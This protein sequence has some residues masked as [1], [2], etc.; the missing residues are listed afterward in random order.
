MRYIL[1]GWE[2]SEELCALKAQEA[3][4]FVNRKNRML[5]G[6]GGGEETSWCATWGDVPGPLDGDPSCRVPSLDPGWGF[7]DEDLL[8]HVVPAVSAD[9]WQV[10]VHSDGVFRQI[11]ASGST[12]SALDRFPVTS[13]LAPPPALSTRPY[14]VAPWP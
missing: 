7:P 13:S 9:D 14:Q 4:D 6:D 1:P 5:R 3:R 11:G 2:L 8:E 10:R 12:F